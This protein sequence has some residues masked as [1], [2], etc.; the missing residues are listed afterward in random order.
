MIV[1]G[2]K[3]MIK[4]ITIN[5]IYLVELLDLLGFRAY[6][7]LLI[8]SNWFITAIFILWRWRLVESA[9]F[10]LYLRIWL[11]LY[12]STLLR[13]YEFYDEGLVLLDCMKSNSYLGLISSI[14]VLGDTFSNLCSIS[15]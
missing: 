15:F 2:L 1:Y 8:S 9:A 6:V 11:S 10:V 12:S 4:Q 3:N 14:E 5:Q 7:M 13:D